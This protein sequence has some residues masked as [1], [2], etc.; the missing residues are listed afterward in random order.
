MLLVALFYLFFFFYGVVLL[1]VP[2]ST[3]NVVNFSCVS[4]ELKLMVRWSW[5]LGG[6]RNWLEHI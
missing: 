5:V 1:Q 4:E 2:F 3:I 6:V